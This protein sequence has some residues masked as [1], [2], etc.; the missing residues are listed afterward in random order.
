MSQIHKNVQV[1]GLDAVCID[2]CQEAAA[3]RQYI[4]EEQPDYL[5]PSP[6][7]CVWHQLKSKLA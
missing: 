7:V 3:F 2:P 1:L 6:G 5:P 4:R